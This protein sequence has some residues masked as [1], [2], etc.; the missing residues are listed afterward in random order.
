M[1]ARI[2]EQLGNQISKDD[3]TEIIKS[4]P[5]SSLSSAIGLNDKFLI[6]REIFNGDK[7]KYDQTIAKLEN[8]A[9]I[10][11]AKAIVSEYSDPDDENEA[12][13]LLLDLVKRKLNPDE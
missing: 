13:V 10:A 8:T 5:I 3:V 1:P 12:M 4:K 9:S 6:M 7:D 2:N 11:D